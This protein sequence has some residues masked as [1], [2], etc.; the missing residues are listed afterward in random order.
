MNHTNG[1]MQFAGI[2]KGS[3]HFSQSKSTH[4]RC[5]CHSFFD[6]SRFLVFFLAGISS[7]GFHSNSGERHG[8][9]AD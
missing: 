8:D 2:Y 6:M 1:G 3:F 5:V 9:S 4:C 7:E